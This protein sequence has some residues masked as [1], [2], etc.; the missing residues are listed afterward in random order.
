[1]CGYPESGGFSGAN[2]RLGI[3]EVGLLSANS[4]AVEGGG[5]G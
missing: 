3:I 5:G 4:V 1:V 2:E